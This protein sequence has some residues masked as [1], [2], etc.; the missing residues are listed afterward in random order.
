MAKNSH[1]RVVQQTARNIAQTVRATDAARRVSTNDSFV[2]FTARLGFGAGSQQDGSH[3]T[4]NF[5]SRNRI[6]LEAAYRSNWVCGMVIDIVAE[7]MTTAGI[8]IKDE[9]LEPADIDKIHKAYEHMALWERQCDTIKW[10]RLY[11]GAIAVLLV[12]G[13]KLNTPLNPDSVGPGMFKGLAVF[14]RWQ[15][16]PSL[17]NLVTE[18]GADLGKPKFYD[19]LP[20]AECLIGEQVHYS[21]VVRL[22][23]TR[24][25]YYQRITENGWGLSI[26]ER[27]YDRVVAFDSTTEG[28]AQ[29]IY[30]AHLR[31]IKIPQLREMIAMGGKSMEGVVAQLQM[32]RQFQSNEGL[33]VLDGT[34][35]FEAFSYTFAGL[36][37]ALLQFGQQLSGA[38]QIP[39]VRLFGQSPAGLNSTGESDLA[40][41]YD[42]I[43]RQQDSVLRSGAGRILDLVHRSELG[44]AP[45]DGFNFE[46]L[47]IGQMTAEEKSTV[48]KNTTDAVL[49]AEEAGVISQQ[50]ALKELRQSS[51]V[52][53]VFGHIS[54]EDIN[55]AESEPPDPS[56][57][58]PMTPLDPTA[59]PE[60]KAVK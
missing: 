21:R 51:R 3:Y 20:G 59:A 25:P 5:T 42:N 16:Q 53:G 2:N 1:H 27:L 7:D 55:S 45:S 49:A 39:L 52:T 33:T 48:A 34:D 32:I 37:D 24:L 12:D 17:Q 26:L 19:I 14:D 4:F 22:E 8:D 31:V 9:S 54:D 11:G 46:F 10:A 28:I 30:K 35:E 15:V 18:Y 58:E 41:Y 40:T 56:E 29:L 23:G 57:M 43:A 38:T 6:N 44:R 36:D 60:L 47:P 13:Q 50:T